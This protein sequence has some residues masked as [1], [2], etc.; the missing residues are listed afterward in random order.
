MNDL[1][2]ALYTKFACDSGCCDRKPIPASVD[3]ESCD[4]LTVSL[5]EELD[6]IKNEMTEDVV[7][8]PHHYI[9]KGGI[10]TID[11]IDAWT[12]G[13]NGIVAVDTANIIKYISRWNKKNGIEDLKKARWY[14]NHLISEMERRMKEDSC[15]E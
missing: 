13:L 5:D 1:K 8:H 2:E 7:N 6:Y 11:V 10:E 12:D 3:F 9:S 4:G 14:L 15:I